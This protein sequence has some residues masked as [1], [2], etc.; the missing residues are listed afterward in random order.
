MREVEINPC[1][2]SVKAHHEPK[3]NP[4]IY[5]PTLV[6]ISQTLY[7]GD[8]F[9]DGKG[10]KDK[11]DLYIPCYIYGKIGVVACEIA[12]LADTYSKD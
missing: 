6:F 2:E 8:D 9:I 10:S 7:Q 3:S 5:S 12:G 11:D 4:W 1:K